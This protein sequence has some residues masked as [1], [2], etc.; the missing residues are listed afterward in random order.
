[1]ARI[2]TS[3]QDPVPVRMVAQQIGGWIAKLGEIWVEG[4]IAQL[5]RRPG[6]ATQF[7]TLRD[8]DGKA[9]VTAM[10]PPGGRQGGGCII[11]GPNNA[12]PYPDHSDAIATLARHFGITLDRSSCYPY[13]R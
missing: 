11:V 2:E 5:S 12:D 10:L 9:L 1:M 8:Q 4:Q 3:P 7:L 13:R 6:V